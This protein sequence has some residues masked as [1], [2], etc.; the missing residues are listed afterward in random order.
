M[1]VT[2]LSGLRLDLLLHSSK[3]RYLSLLA[4]RLTPLAPANVRA[5]M[6]ERKTM[7]R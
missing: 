7:T 5:G 1:F 4:R 3:D 2:I 6:T